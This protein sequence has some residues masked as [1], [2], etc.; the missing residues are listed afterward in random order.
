MNV[1]ALGLFVCA[2]SS[3]LAI[4]ARS[5]RLAALAVCLGLVGATAYP[6]L[7]AP[8]Q[9]SFPLSTYP[10]FARPR[11]TAQTIDYAVGEAATGERRTLRP[12]HLGSG[13]VLQA[14]AVLNGARKARTLPAL[15]TTIAARVAADA[16]LADVTRIRIV[17]GTHDAVDYLVRHVRGNEVERARCEVTR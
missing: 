17:S 14:L 15:C 3:A 8:D 1:I 4:V 10:M 2:V 12:R 6:V 5:R 16:E 7:L 11:K 9:D 13:E